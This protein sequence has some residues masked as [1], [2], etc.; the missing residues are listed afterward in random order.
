VLEAA[1]LTVAEES[2]YLALLRQGPASPESL[3]GWVQMPPR[4]LLRVVNSLVR[5]GL[6]QRTPPPAQTIV[7]VPAD[8]AIE[9]L[10]ARRHQE[11]EQVRQNMGRMVAAA[12]AQKRSTGAD[13]LVEV[14]E[15]RRAVQQTFERLQQTARDEV[16]SLVAPPYAGQD[17]INETELRRLATGVRYRAIYDEAALAEPGFVASIA[18]YLAAGEDARLVATVPIKLVVADRALAMLPL[19]WTSTAR[20]A[21][22]VVRPCGLLDALTALFEVVWASATPLSFTGQ[23]TVNSRLELTNGDRQLLSLLVSGL[24]DEAVGARLGMSRR[25]VVRRVHHL[26]TVSG[27]RSRLQLGWQA[28]ERGWL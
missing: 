26:M 15:G 17:P 3:A 28:R 10:I 5:H 1:G 19:T 20:D 21:A 11:L 18:N 9:R 23:D 6:A 14:V 25:T 27:A 24:T 8:V 22:M 7:A 16:R 2:T 4:R 13:D 12:L